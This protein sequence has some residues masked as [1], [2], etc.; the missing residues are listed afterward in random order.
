MTHP[1]ERQLNAAAD[2]P[3]IVL[4]SCAAGGLILILLLIIFGDKF[5]ALF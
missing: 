1:T 5:A 3:M 2:L 4:I